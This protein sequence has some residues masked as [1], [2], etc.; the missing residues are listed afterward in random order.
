M[1]KYLYIAKS[2]KGEAKS[3][4]LEAPDEHQLARILRSEGY[5][6]TSVSI[7]EPEKK[8]FSFS[9]PFS[10]GVSLTEK[11]LFT[12]NLQIMIAAGI[13]LPKALTI[14]SNQ[15]KS[16]KMKSA[17]LEVENEI[18]KGKSFAD[19]LAKHP[20]IFN[21]FF[22]SII[23]VGEESGTLEESL[24]VL[25]RQMEREHELRSKIIG[26]MVYPAV[27][28]CAMI[29]V[30]ILMLV[31]V[32]PKL[33]ETF[34]DLNVELPA[35]TRF[36]IALANF[37]VT[38]W[39]ILVLIIIILI[40]LIRRVSKTS[41]GKR[42][43]DS[44]SLKFPIISPIIKKT[45]AAHTV[46]TLSSLIVSGVPIIEAL[47]IVAGTLGNVYFKN[48]IV[49]AT[50]K[51]KKGIKLSE[52]L[53]P[54]DKLFSP[55]VIQM[56]QVGEETG[57]TSGILLKLADFF[58]EEITEVTRN[59]SSVIEPLLMLLIGGVVGFFAISMFQPIYSMLGSIQ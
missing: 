37:F 18:I 34:R 55:L 43:F 27:I 13:A 12:R 11:M 4:I 6:L 59:L 53:K 9:F 49:D 2:L 41:P 44:V 3:G 47:D 21:K 35:T 52:A 26:A 46:R 28:I 10:R 36:I 5:L 17:L 48:A 40:F 57:E 38:K 8:K 23:K 58:E 14:L 19:S 33:A 16:K 54:Y 29:G 39:Y 31:M 15:M 7:E 30:G 1:P 50:E 20:N 25:T 24:K 22:V 51:V 45:Y 56:I 32:I 42:F